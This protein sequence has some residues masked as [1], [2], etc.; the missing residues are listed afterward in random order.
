MLFEIEQSPTINEKLLENFKKYCKQ[1]GIV[2]CYKNKLE[3]NVNYN[4]EVEK[5]I[6]NIENK[7]IDNFK[8][9]WWLDLID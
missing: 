9:P 3:L 2:Q 5:K 4:I 8:L 1:F 7:F 6:K